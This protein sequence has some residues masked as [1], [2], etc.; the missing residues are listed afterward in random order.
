MEE[1]KHRGLCFC[2][3]ALGHEHKSAAAET[4][5]SLMQF[6]HPLLCVKNYYCFLIAFLSPQQTATFKKWNAAFIVARQ[7]F[8]NMGR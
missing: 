2:R 1:V 3:A 4:R 8:G 6:F 5:E 7:V